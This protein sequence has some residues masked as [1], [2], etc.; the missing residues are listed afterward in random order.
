MDSFIATTPF[1]SS[2]HRALAARVA[3][4]AEREIEVRAGDDEGDVD[5][6]VR[7]YVLLLAEA[8]LLRYAIASPGQAFDLRSFCI[9][10]EILSYSS[11][12]ADLAFTMQGLGT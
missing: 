3:E 8:D 5:E 9:I 4:F 12:L 7:G 2:D 11:S 6:A 1:F 10:R